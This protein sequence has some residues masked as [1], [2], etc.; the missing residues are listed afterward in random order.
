MCKQVW[1]KDTIRSIK[2]ILRLFESNSV[3]GNYDS[4]VVFDGEND[5]GAGITFGAEQT[6]E[7]GGGLFK[8][9]KLYEDLEG[10]YSLLLKPFLENLYDGEDRS[11]KDNLTYNTKFREILIKAARKDPIMKSAQ[12]LFFEQHYLVPAFDLFDQYSFKLP[13]TAAIIYDTCIHS[14]PGDY[15]AEEPEKWGAALLLWRFDENR[16]TPDLPGL[17]DD[18]TMCGVGGL[19]PEDEGE[20]EPWTDQDF[21]NAEKNFI[22]DYVLDRLKWL[23]THKK[24]SVR[25][26][27]YRMHSFLKLISDDKWDLDLDFELHRSK[28]G[29]RL[30]RPKLIT[31]ENIKNL[32]VVDQSLLERL[33]LAE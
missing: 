1:T 18:E 31:S 5:D 9:L 24:K 7:N 15:L 2:A 3:E 20:I 10:F 33:D 32:Q 14:G 23:E 13:L 19:V 8:L 27:T 11:K 30:K 22:K 21:E 26:T 4:L 16:T 17:E 12:D 28:T 25:M 29:K 6:T